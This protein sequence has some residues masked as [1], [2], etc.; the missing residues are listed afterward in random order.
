MRPFLHASLVNGRFG[1]PAVYVETLFEKGA[2]LFDLGDLSSLPP[3]KLDRIE[4][5]FVSHTHV[6]H[7][8]GF[9]RLLRILVGR[10]KRVRLY[11]PAGFIA[12]VYHKLAAYRWNLV[13]RYAADLVFVVT[14]VAPDL[15]IRAAELSF[16]NRFEIEPVGACVEG[17]GILCAEPLF[18]VSTAVLDHRGPCLAFAVE[19]TAHVNVWKN[20]LVAAGLPVG[21]WLNTLKRALLEN[22]GDDH[23]I[24][25]AAAGAAD[26]REAPLGLLRGLVTITPGQKIGYVT[27]AADTAEN[28]RLIVRLALGAD[29]L[30][31]EAPF[32]AAD[33]ELA[34]DRAHLTTAAAGEIAR[35]AGVR[36]IEPFHFSP[37]Y[38]GEEARMVGEVAAS[39]AGGR[40]DRG[41]IQGVRKTSASPSS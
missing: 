41:W 4:H 5:V 7:F 6:D 12:Q 13:D 19:E 39:F 17:E 15:K 30:F 20:R 18:R 37:R 33:A 28:R 2:I 22:R 9:D 8:F 25:I 24:R 32:A 3:R 38:E 27:D 11:G 29:L 34:A 35:A 26:T 31:I 1:D 36:R 10:D 14:E 21:P 23:P 40:V 16:K